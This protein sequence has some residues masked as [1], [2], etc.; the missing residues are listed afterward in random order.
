ML[1]LRR[2]SE[3]EFINALEKTAREMGYTVERKDYTDCKETYTFQVFHNSM[4]LPT[5]KNEI[6][7]I[8]KTFTDGDV[9][10][11]KFTFKKDDHPDWYMCGIR[12][13]YK[14]LENFKNYLIDFSKNYKQYLEWQNL[15]DLKE[16]F[17]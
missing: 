1:K 4:K 2:L 9:E 7:G 13:N 17:E 8:I 14:C 6:M 15:K 11:W 16:D 3:T 12:F 5:H 10:C